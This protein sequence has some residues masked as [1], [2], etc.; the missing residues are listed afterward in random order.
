MALTKFER[1]FVSWA[2]KKYWRTN[3][4]D[5]MKQE[6]IEYAITGGV[7]T[8]RA[9]NITPIERAKTSTNGAY[10]SGSLSNVALFGVEHTTKSNVK[11]F[12]QGSKTINP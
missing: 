3:K 4:R 12:S 9:E 7:N 5:R 10:S 8:E 6:M 2:V 11:E 1:M